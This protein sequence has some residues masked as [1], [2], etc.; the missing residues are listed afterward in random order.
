MTPTTFNTYDSYESAVIP[1]KD[2]IPDSRSP[3]WMVI[4]LGSAG[5]TKIDAHPTREHST[6]EEACAEAERL[7]AKHPSHARG[8]AVLQARRV[9]RAEV[10]ITTEHLIG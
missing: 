2:P 10:T 9:V 4:R 5:V 8:F 3:F 7:A 6:Y 1:A